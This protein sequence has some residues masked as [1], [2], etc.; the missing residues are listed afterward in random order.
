MKLE[1][2]TIA[3]LLVGGCSDTQG[4]ADESLLDSYLSYC[5]ELAVGKEQIVG[6]TWS[7]EA[8]Y[9]IVF[10]DERY[11]SFR[12]EEFSYSGGAHGNRQVIVG[13][14]DRATGRRLTVRDLIPAER[15]EQVLKSLRQKVVERLGGEDK[16]QGEV[17]LTENCCLGADGL[18]FVYNEYEVACYAEGMIE[19]IIPR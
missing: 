11:L 12:A 19:V 5:R 15:R 1:L 16:L 2:L 18:H 4:E 14:F 10:A 17:T 9:N 8:T 7:T 3:A 13:T 6:A